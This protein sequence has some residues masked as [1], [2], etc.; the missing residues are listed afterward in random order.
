MDSELDPACTQ[1]VAARWHGQIPG[2]RRL[3]RHRS[4]G[5][6]QKRVLISTWINGNPWVTEVWSVDP[7]SKHQNELVPRKKEQILLEVKMM[8][9]RCLA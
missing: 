4:W 8:D 7:Q 1:T 9:I 3:C 6:N 2:I 5:E